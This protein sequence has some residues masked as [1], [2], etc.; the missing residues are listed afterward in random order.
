MHTSNISKP[1]VTRSKRDSTRANAIMH[2]H[3]NHSCL[4][5]SKLP[6]IQHSPQL[7]QRCNDVRTDLG[8]ELGRPEPGCAQFWQHQ[9]QK[10]CPS[11]KGPW[12][13]ARTG[14]ASFAAHGAPT[15]LLLLCLCSSQFLPWLSSGPV[16]PSQSLS[17]I[18]CPQQWDSFYR[19]L[20][21]CFAF[22]AW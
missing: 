1:E 11:G 15:S 16:S 17:H 18:F 9:A 12:H 8:T 13:L 10:T 21:A 3:K 5:H 2:P 7:S 20:A 19:G 4:L 14:T 22:L 6:A